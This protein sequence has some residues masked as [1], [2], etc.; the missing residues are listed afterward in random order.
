[1]QHLTEEQLVA[2]Y[3]RDDDAETAG[4]HLGACPTCG[5]EYESIRGVLLLVTDAPVPERGDAYGDQV[6]T[7]VRWKLGS[8]R[9]RAGWIT[10][11]AAAAAL[12]FAFF[13][14]QWWSVGRPRATAPIATATAAAADGRP[15][16]EQG[17][18]VLLL[19]VGD[20]LDSTE[21]ILLELANADPQKT[22][23]F[24]QES[25]RA[26]ELV[27][28][29]RIY[30]QTAA[31]DGNQRIASIL[32]DIEPVLIEISH[33]GAKLSAEDVAELQRRIEAKGLL[34]KVRVISAET[35]HHPRNDNG[36][37]SNRI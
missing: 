36:H 20:H 10:G 3:Y 25:R 33:A 14:G 9:R 26:G 37:E 32:A 13:A 31:Q 28:A 27:S 6:W 17:E 15:S 12:A 11:L 22:L 18:K 1:M 4:E 29:N 30:R 21:R 16:T 34:F 19:V 35:T 7:R 8:Q 2:H 24:G 23:D 5:A